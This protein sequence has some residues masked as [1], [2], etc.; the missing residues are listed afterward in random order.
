MSGNC[1]PSSPNGGG[2]CLAHRSVVLRYWRLFVCLQIKMSGAI[3][4]LVMLFGSYLVLNSQLEKLVT[5]LREDELHCS[6]TVGT[7]DWQLRAQARSIWY[8]ISI[9]K[10]IEKTAE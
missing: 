10:R 4:V 3:L 1:P 6:L 8:L 9:I 7:I 2:D 5:R